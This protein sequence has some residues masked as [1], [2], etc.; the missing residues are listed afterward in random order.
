MIRQMLKRIPGLSAVIA[1]TLANPR[2]P[3]KKLVAGE[4]DKELPMLGWEIMP[5]AVRAELKEVWALQKGRLTVIGVARVMQHG[6]AR[7]VCQCG[8]GRYVRRR[9]RDLISKHA[10]TDACAICKQFALMVNTEYHKQHKRNLPE[11]GFFLTGINRVNVM[12]EIKSLNEASA[13]PQECDGCGNEKPE[14]TK[15]CPHCGGCKCDVCDMGDD[16]SC[17]CC[18]GEE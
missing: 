9:R 14:Y 5:E 6:V 1:W 3:L 12:N 7:Y 8:C 17:I 18:E 13:A 11:N 10:A 16:T 4:G 2:A 15:N